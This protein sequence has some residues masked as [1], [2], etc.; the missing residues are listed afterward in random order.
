LAR[1][2]ADATLKGFFQGVYFHFL[3][4]GWPRVPFAFD[5][6]DFISIMKSRIA[7][8][9]SKRSWIP[10]ARLSQLL[11]GGRDAPNEIDDMVMVYIRK[12]VEE[13]RRWMRAAQ[14][15]MDQLSVYRSDAEFIRLSIN[16]VRTFDRVKDLSEVTHGSERLS[17]KMVPGRFGLHEE[18]VASFRKMAENR[19]D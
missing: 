3:R 17:G 8:C 4:H 18:E 19:Y 5:R 16:I 2:N 6:P 10:A 11:F 7:E 13:L 12:E 1:L 9:S 14:D 15:E